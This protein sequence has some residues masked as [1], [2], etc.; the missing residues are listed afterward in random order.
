MMKEHGGGIQ[1]SR[2]GR[3]RK[4][5]MPNLCLGREEIRSECLMTTAA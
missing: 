3:A 2:R 5:R 1:I 4:K